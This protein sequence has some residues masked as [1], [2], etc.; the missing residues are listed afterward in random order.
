MNSFYREDEKKKL[1]IIRIHIYILIMKENFRIYRQPKP[2]FKRA[3]E[4]KLLAIA[5][6]KN[7]QKRSLEKDRLFERLSIIHQ[8]STA[9]NAK[10]DIAIHGAGY[11]AQQLNDPIKGYK[12]MRDATDRGYAQME[13]QPTYDYT[14]EVMKKLK[15]PMMA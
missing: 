1:A 5:S 4:N 15:T 13:N 10:I 3:V 8:R 7:E 11:V 12:L 6:I 14:L 2:S 9:R